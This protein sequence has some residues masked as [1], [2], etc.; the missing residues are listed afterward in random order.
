MWCDVLLLRSYA[1]YLSF[2]LFAPQHDVMTTEE[3]PHPSCISTDFLL[4]Q[5][6]RRWSFTPVTNRLNSK[7]ARVGVCFPALFF[8]KVKT[9]SKQPSRCQNWNFFTWGLQMNSSTKPALTKKLGSSNF[10]INALWKF[11]D[12]SRQVTLKKTV[13]WRA[14]EFDNSLAIDVLKASRLDIQVLK[15]TVLF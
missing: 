10:I 1:N 8:S 15:I 3:L 5:S 6:Q 4:K 13:F 7:R 12:L 9:G 11:T 14:F 2:F